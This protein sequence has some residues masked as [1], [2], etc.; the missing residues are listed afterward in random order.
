MMFGGASIF[1]FK[2][3]VLLLIPAVPLHERGSHE[4]ESSVHL[5]ATV[6]TTEGTEY[7]FRKSL[8]NSLE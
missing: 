5:T 8:W 3:S 4:L 2:M 1:K 6:A 7:N